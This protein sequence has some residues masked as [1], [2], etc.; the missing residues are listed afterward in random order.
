MDLIRHH[1]YPEPACAFGNPAQFVE[2]VH[3]PR[4][5]VWIAQQVGDL[6]ARSARTREGFLQGVQINSAVGVKRRFDHST[7]VVRH[8]CVERGVHRRVDDDGVAAVGDQTQ[9]LNDTEHHVRNDRGT[10]DLQ[11]VPLPTLRGEFTDRLGER[12][13]GGIAGIT[14]VDSRSEGVGHCRRELDVHL[15]DPQRQH[16]DRVRAPLHAG[17]EP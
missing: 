15:C 4:R 2:R 17:A 10:T 9:R 13:A 16:V 5:I 1:P 3:R 7:A 8:K 14:I 12:G 11:V 6:P